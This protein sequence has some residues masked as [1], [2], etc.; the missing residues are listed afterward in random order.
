MASAP[1]T[2][3]S[4]A[5]VVPIEVRGHDQV[6]RGRSQPGESWWA[7]AQ[8]LAAPLA[9]EPVALDLSGERKVFG[10]DDLLV[11]TVRAMTRGDLPDVAGWRAQPHVARWWSADGATDLATVTER[12]A[13][14]I[15]GRTPTTMWV[16]EANGRSVG[17]VQDYRFSDYPDYPVV[18]AAPGA[19]GVDYLVGDLVRV[20][21]GLGTR[22]LWAWVLRAHHRFPEAGQLFAAP[23]HRNLA[24]R[25]LLAKL[26]FVEGL[27]FDEPRADGTRSTVVGHGLD[28]RTVVG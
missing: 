24:S 18:G 16:I 5:D 19:I 2:S 8:R 25:R 26:G 14:A 12:Y 22:A 13:D 11:V 27:W 15:D 17:L 21:R 9:G 10:I 3:S 6:L 1:S 20:D 28:V 7:A 23:D 4:L